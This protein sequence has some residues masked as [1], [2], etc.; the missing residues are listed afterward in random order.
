LDVVAS[1]SFSI[2]VAYPIATAK[3]TSRIPIKVPENTNLKNFILSNFYK[4]HTSVPDFI[5]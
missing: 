5:H 3:V 2:K 4:F 1:K